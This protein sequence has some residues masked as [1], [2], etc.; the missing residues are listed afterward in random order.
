MDA[1]SQGV[2]GVMSRERDKLRPGAQAPRRGMRVAECGS[3]IRG[4]RHETML[5]LRARNRE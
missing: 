2:P 4:T 3:S 5:P 1:L